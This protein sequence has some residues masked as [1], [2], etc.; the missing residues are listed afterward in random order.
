MTRTYLVANGAP[1]A[2]VALLLLLT[3]G[4]RCD[5]APD[6]A[7]GT[8]YVHPKGNDAWS[9]KLAVPT[10]DRTDGPK[11]SLAGARDAVRA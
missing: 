8:F 9:G 6:G 2:A 1:L 11:A 7:S 3:L 5:G 10:A 4:A